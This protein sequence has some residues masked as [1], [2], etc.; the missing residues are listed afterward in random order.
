M[1]PLI[2]NIYKTLNDNLGSY[3]YKYEVSKHDF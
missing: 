1:V 3:F 2:S